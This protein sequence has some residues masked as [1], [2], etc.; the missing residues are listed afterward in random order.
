MII[1]TRMAYVAGSICCLG[2]FA[3]CDVQ[4]CPV[5]IV[6]S[7][8]PQHIF[9]LYTCSFFFSFVPRQLAIRDCCHPIGLPAFCNLMQ[10]PTRCFVS[11]CQFVLQRQ[12]HDCVSVRVVDLWFLESRHA[13]FD[14]D[15]TCFIECSIS[16]T[17]NAR[18]WTVLSYR[19]IRGSTVGTICWSGESPVADVGCFMQRALRTLLAAD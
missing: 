11:L 16:D 8:Y 4:D 14:N 3:S 1:H 6:W 2:A 10:T 19:T 17:W 5:D 7:C 15:L 9:H 13:W 18:L 12:V